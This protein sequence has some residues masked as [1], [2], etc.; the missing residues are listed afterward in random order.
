MHGAP[1]VNYILLRVTSKAQ[2]LNFSTAGSKTLNAILKKNLKK[3]EKVGN[4]FIRF[5][6]SY[7]YRFNEKKKKVGD[8]NSREKKR[9]VVKSSSNYKKSKPLR[10]T[11][12]LLFTYYTI[13]HTLSAIFSFFFFTVY[14]HKI[15]S[16][17]YQYSFVHKV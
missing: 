2:R 6:L 16:I 1:C 3:Q 4:N 13:Y 9:V 12:E 7:L 15:N 17:R 14:T 10:L 5:S 11:H 8:L